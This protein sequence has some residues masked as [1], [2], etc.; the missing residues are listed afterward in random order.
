MI[1]LLGAGGAISNE[2][3]KF[4]AARKQPFRLVGRSPHAVSGPTEIIAADLSDQD[5]TVRATAGSSVVCLLVGLKYDHII[6]AELWPR[7][8]ANTIEACKRAGAK[9]IFFDNVYPYGKVNGAMTENTPFNPCSRKGEI[10]AKIANTLI[11]QWKAGALTA[12]IARS[13]DFYGPDT[14]NGV[15]NVLVF[16]PLSKIAS[17]MAGK[18]F[19]PA[20][21]HLHETPRGA[22]DLARDSARDQTWHA[23]RAKSAYRERVCGDGRKRV[24]SPPEIPRP[25]Q[26]YPSPCRFV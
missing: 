12:M 4:L 18:R 11:A 15:P 9:L 8:M 24:W 1:T 21:P 14:R 17:L 5:Q 16:E 10:R 19:G 6:W 3:V 25:A 23:D 7:I 20:L 22:H 2:L 13:A 26:A